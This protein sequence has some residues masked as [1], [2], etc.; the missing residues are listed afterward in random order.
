MCSVC[1]LL[2]MYEE[3]QQKGCVRHY[4]LY[5]QLDH[6]KTPFYAI[7]FGLFRNAQF[8]DQINPEHNGTDP[9]PSCSQRHYVA[10]ARSSSKCSL[11]APRESEKRCPHPSLMRCENTQNQQ[12]PQP[13]TWH[14]VTL[15][16]RF[17]VLAPLHFVVTRHVC[18][19][20]WPFVG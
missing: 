14:D 5:S 20:T 2:P 8:V 7:K 17:N 19:S 9:L 13:M 10:R 4:T 16:G 3:K 6:A 12:D 11:K 18:L 15:A 1:I